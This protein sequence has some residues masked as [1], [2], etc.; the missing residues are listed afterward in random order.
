MRFRFANRKLELMYT[1]GRDTGRYGHELVNAFVKVLAQL[2]AAIDE[3][4][5]YRQRGLRY[6]KL[7]GDRAGQYSVRLN[8]QWRLILRPDKDRD[9]NFI[10]IIE[11]VDYH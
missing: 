6:E 10:W 4:D 11:V 2:D 1:T 3:R 7:R 5:L 8:K 9:G